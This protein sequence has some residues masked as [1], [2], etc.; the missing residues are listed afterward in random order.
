MKEQ[1]TQLGVAVLLGALG[2]FWLVV[3]A[4][5]RRHGQKRSR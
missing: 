1:M 2:L 3:V 5:V 4:L